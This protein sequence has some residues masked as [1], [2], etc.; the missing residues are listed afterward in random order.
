MKNRIIKLLPY[1]E[2]AINQLFNRDRNNQII[3]PDNPEIA[4]EYKGYISSFG[5]AVMQSGLLPALYFNHQSDNSD[6]DRKKLMN[7]IF[8]VIKIGYNINFNGNLL[9]YAKQDNVNLKQL[10]KQILDAATAVKLVIR[11]Y[12]L[13]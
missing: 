2:N 9:K 7:V 13:K 3:N 6:K 4:K 10:E 1:A 11:T 5:A 8:D 12:K